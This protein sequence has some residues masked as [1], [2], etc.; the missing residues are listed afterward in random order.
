MKLIQLEEPNEF[1]TDIA[2]KILSSILEQLP[3]TTIDESKPL[4]I[5]EA[6]AFIGLAKQTL[7]KFTSEGT[8]PH[9]KQ[10][11]KLFFFREE[12]IEWIKGNSKSPK[13]HLR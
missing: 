10:G 12:L 1:A 13:I 8:I 9:H 3:S 2:N 11:G 5:E 6:S 7:Y 4:S